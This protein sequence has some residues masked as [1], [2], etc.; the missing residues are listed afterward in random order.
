MIGLTG[1]V[2][3]GK[4]TVAG[5]LRELGAEI[6]DADQIA[7]EIVQPGQPALGEIVEAFGAEVLDAR[8]RLSRE[9]LAGIVFADAAAR[10]RLQEI[11]HPRIIAESQ[12]RLDELRERGVKVAVY[13]AAL[14]VETGR[15]R[16]MDALIVVVAEEAEQIR[17]LAERDGMDETQARGRLAAQLPTS[18]KSAVAQHIVRCEGPLEDVRRRVEAVWRTVTRA[19]GSLP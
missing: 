7:R 1:G 2:A 5:M 9:R 13:E 18:A 15:Y 10:H 6:V 16:S 8:G 17:R 12:R 4:T 11:T 19:D 14:L 3:S